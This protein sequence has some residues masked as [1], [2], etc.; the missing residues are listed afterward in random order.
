MGLLASKCTVWRGSL[1]QEE[2]KKLNV[3]AVRNCGINESQ[4]L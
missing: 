4:V 2:G 1:K 3:G